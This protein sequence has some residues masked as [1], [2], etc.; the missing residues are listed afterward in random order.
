M[1]FK[2]IMK[3]SQFK[4]YMNENLSN[5]SYWVENDFFFQRLALELYT[6]M[7]F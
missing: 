2:I 7:Y 3:F 4:A 1:Q 5:Y 6:I